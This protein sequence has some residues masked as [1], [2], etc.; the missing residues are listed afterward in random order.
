MISEFIAFYFAHICMENENIGAVCTF[1]IHH[2]AFYDGN[3]VEL[4][5][6]ELKTSLSIHCEKKLI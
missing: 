5:K 6:I 4:G 2:K 1:P 3:N